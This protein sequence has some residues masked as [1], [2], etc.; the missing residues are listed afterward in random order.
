MNLPLKITLLTQEQKERLAKE[1][2]DRL[3]FREYGDM[4]LIYAFTLPETDDNYKLYE[5]EKEVIT[6]LCNLF[7][8]CLDYESVCK[9]HEAL[10]FILG[11]FAKM[12]EEDLKNAK[13]IFDGLKAEAW[14]RFEQRNEE[15]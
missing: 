11:E 3:V 4:T 1:R 13:K 12:H 9:I 6:N 5:V 14:K 10:D 2:A 7:N 15:K 8:S